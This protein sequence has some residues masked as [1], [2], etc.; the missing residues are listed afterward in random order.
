M[1]LLDTLRRQ[2]PSTAVERA[3][4]MS[5]TDYFAIAG[6]VY[7]LGLQT[8]YPRS[9]SMTI[10][11]DLSGFVE[12]VQRKSPVVAAAVAKRAGLV[13]E[14]QF[15]WRNNR[16]SSSPGRTFGTPALGVLERPSPDVTAPELLAAAEVDV[17]FAG[18]AFFHRPRP[19]LLRRLRPDWVQCVYGSD[20]D[21]DKPLEQHDLHLIG[22]AYLPGGVQRDAVPLPFEEVAYWAPEPGPLPGTGWSWVQGLIAEITADRA[23]TEYRSKFYENGA[24][25]N[26]VFVMDKETKV[27]AIKAFRR[28]NEE[29]TSGVRNAY[30]NMYLGGGADVRVVGANL[31]ALSFRDSQGGDETRI[32]LRSQVPASILGTRE[33]MQGSSLNA[34]NYTAQ[35]RAWADTWFAPHGRSLC[36]ALERIVP[37]PG[38]DAEL[39]YDRDAIPFLQEDG[40]DA[41]NIAQTQAQ[42]IR[43]LVEA[44]YEPDAAVAA[45]KTGDLAALTG[46]HTGVFSVQLQPP[47]SGQQPDA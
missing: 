40:Q 21:P 47:T 30:K 44:G 31:D 43:A 35:R 29:A 17:S 36:K 18:V 24:T 33:G 23:A 20:V 45:V 27:E 7:P 37:P 6:H 4:T 41:A 12:T 34:G 22:F 26:L 14:I 1:R 46:R 8:L 9:G 25:P 39:S 11:T 16:L 42:A 3:V 32:A 2:E 38:P 10:P 13:S 28:M 15:V 5:L 19:N